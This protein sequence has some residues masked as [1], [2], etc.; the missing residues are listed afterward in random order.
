ML[1]SPKPTVMV[2]KMATG[3]ITIL[4]KIAK[5]TASNATMEPTD[6]SMPPVRITINIPI[7]IMPIPETCFNKLD[8]LIDV[9]KTSDIIEEKS[10]NSIKMNIV[11]CLIKNR[12]I[13]LAVFSCCIVEVILDGF[14]FKKK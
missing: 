13:P 7:L 3:K 4:T 5:T 1:P 10:T 11:L 2:I 14:E 8:R 12:P 9:K 6:K